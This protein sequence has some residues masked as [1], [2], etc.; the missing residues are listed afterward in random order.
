MGFNKM[1]DPLVWGDDPA[2]I[3][4]KAIKDIDAVFKRHF[5]RSATMAELHY[6]FICAI[7]GHADKE[8]EDRILSEYNKNRRIYHQ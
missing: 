1:A 2:E 4:A 7:N 5:D 8:E 6:G 3:A